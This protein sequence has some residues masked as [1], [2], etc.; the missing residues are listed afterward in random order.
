MKPSLFFE[1]INNIDKYLA[2]LT[3]KK[4]FKLLKSVMKVMILLLPYK[5]KKVISEYDQ[6]SC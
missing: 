4:R 6:Q 1:K 3:V 2:S 5:N